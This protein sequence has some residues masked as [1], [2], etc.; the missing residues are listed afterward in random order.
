MIPDLRSILTAAA[1][2]GSIAAVTIRA[3]SDHDFDERV[4]QLL[5][6]P[7]GLALQ[8]DRVIPYYDGATRAYRQATLLRS[9]TIVVTIDLDES[10]LPVGMVVTERAATADAMIIDLAKLQ[11]LVSRMASDRDAITIVV[12]STG[13]SIHVTISDPNIAIAA[14]SAVGA[15]I[16]KLT[17]HAEWNGSEWDEADAVLDGMN[18]AIMT[19]HRKIAVERAA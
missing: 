14:L 4:R 7:D 9:R 11:P 5:D 6:A 13:P 2:A 15:E 8:S 12:G 16:V 18:V 1:S 3:T 10:A 19:P 17:R